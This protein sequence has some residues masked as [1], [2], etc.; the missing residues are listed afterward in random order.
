LESIN[1]KILLH[2]YALFIKLSSH[3]ASE[4]MD[5]LS[6]VFLCFYYTQLGSKRPCRRT[7]LANSNETGFLVSMQNVRQ[8]PMKLIPRLHDQAII[9][10]T[11]SKHNA[12]VFKILVHDVC[13]NCSIF[14]RR[15]LNV[16]YI[17]A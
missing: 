7:A 11:F 13:S 2:A 1:A 9:K 5:F 4:R 16:C 12:N 8:Q 6:A 15:L 3:M 17:F 14:A 10:Q